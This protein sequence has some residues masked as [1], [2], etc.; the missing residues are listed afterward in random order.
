MN[1]FFKILLKDYNIMY[2]N[3]CRTLVNR[4]INTIIDY[5]RF[6]AI[7]VSGILLIIGICYNQRDLALFSVF[8]VWINNMAWCLEEIKKR[9]IFFFFQITMYI[10]II[11]RP[12]YQFF[13]GE[14]WFHYGQKEFLF[15]MVALWL[16]LMCM[17][18]GAILPSKLSLIKNHDSSLVSYNNEFLKCLR[19]VSCAVFIISFA[20][21][22]MVGLE[23]VLFILNNSYAEYYV[24]FKSS[25]PYVLRVLAS[26]MPYSICIFLS[27]NPSKKVSF[28]VLSLY[29]I[30]AIPNFIVGTR[31]P[32]ILNLLFAL[33]YY[34]IRDSL[35]DVKKWFGKFEKCVTII[36]AP[37]IIIVLFFYAYVRA[38][39]KIPHVG[40]NVINAFIYQ[41]GT[42]F[43]VLS[44]GYDSLEY[45]P[46]NKNYTFGG[47]IDY[48]THGTIAQHFLGAIDLGGGNSVTMGIESNS[49]A[50]NMSYIMHPEYLNG[51]G[52]GSSYILEVF[53]DFGYFGIIVYSILIGLL[54]AIVIQLCKKNYALYTMSLVILMQLY[55]TPRSSA[56]G[57]LNPIFQKPFIACFVGCIVCAFALQ[58]LLIRNKRFK[59]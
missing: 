47:L 11:G 7:M 13:K 20:V 53:A 10:F 30:S 33:T 36:C 16:T 22:A 15:C 2:K 56:L 50:H 14:N 58:K 38:G 59:K 32:I 44:I 3:I 46:N 43:D 1:H 51:Q 9:F 41:Q 35:G 12:I 17:Y 57:F 37:I 8:I 54:M 39:L 21:E 6:A 5:V 19:I 28:V 42:T 52:W 55:F 26:F 25:L 24:S 4:K 29:V 34:L 31:N 27:T 49:F 48:Y 23:R 18:L 45:L 40:L